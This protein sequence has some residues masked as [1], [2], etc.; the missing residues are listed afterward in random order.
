MGQWGTEMCPLSRPY[1][2]KPHRLDPPRQ[3]LHSPPVPCYI[4]CSQSENMGV[5]KDRH[6]TIQ[7]SACAIYFKWWSDNAYIYR[8]LVWNPLTYLWAHLFMQA[9]AMLLF[10]ACGS[11]TLVGTKTCNP[12]KTCYIS[13]AHIKK[14]RIRGWGDGP[15]GKVFT[16]IRA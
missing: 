3:R 4:S 5:K 2:S 16:V 6:V 8:A 13:K 1:D 7:R 9:R 11:W 15:I 14:E 12:Y 10:S